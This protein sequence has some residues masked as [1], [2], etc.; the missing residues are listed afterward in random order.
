M[1]RTACRQH[2]SRDTATH[3]FHRCGLAWRVTPKCPAYCCYVT[4]TALPH[5]P[6]NTLGRCRLQHPL[7]KHAR[8]SFGEK[9]SRASGHKAM[10]AR[11]SR[12]LADAMP[13]GRRRKAVRAQFELAPETRANAPT[14]AG[15]GQ[16][17][18][19]VPQLTMFLELKNAVQLLTPSVHTR[20][21][22]RWGPA[23]TCGQPRQNRVTILVVA[24]DENLRRVGGDPHAHRIDCMYDASRTRGPRAGTFSARLAC[25]GP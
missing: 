15:A 8:L 1:S 6:V 9:G 14:K 19:G 23:N 5:N 25:R 21:P 20:P 13:R 10:V 7:A 12:P 24:A 22:H 17:S 18:N 4:T 3:T 11:C 2:A 16:R